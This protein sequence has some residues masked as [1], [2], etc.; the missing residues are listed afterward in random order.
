MQD[1]DRPRR[2]L[3]FAALVG[4]AVALWLAWPLKG[5][6]AFALV[7]GYLLQPLQRRVERIVKRP[8]LAGLVVVLLAALAIVLPFA[9]GGALVAR[10]ARSAME[11]GLNPDQAT[12]T[13]VG[14]ATRLGVPEER[15]RQGVQDALA[16]AGAT[17]QEHAPVAAMGIATLLVDFFVFLLLLYF[18]LLAWPRLRR[19]ADQVLPFETRDRE[20]LYDRAGER[21]KALVVGSVAI[22]AVQG[23]VGGLGWWLLGLPDPLLWGLVMFLLEL[24]PLL[25]SFIVLLPAAIWRATQGDWVDVGGLLALN[26]VAVGLID[27]WLRA[28]LVGRWGHIEPGLVLVGIVGGLTLMGLP[29]LLIG[30]LLLGMLPLVLCAWSGQE[31]PFAPQKREEK[32]GRLRRMA[33]RVRERMGHRG[34]PG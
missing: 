23:C 10:E 30:P 11:G 32:D 20:E 24:V 22:A 15:A 26:F 21:V 31:R 2:F 28:A 1:A 33:R 14:L 16:G 25:G 12:T 5:P 19:F 13:L 8:G 34:R 6:I 27:D 18:L 3:T 4:V 7:L 9:L 17:L 29:G